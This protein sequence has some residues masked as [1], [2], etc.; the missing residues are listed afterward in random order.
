MHAP[1]PGTAGQLPPHAHPSPMRRARVHACA[2]IRLGIMIG[3][4]WISNSCT[5][6]LG[7][8]MSGSA[9]RPQR[10]RFPQPKHKACRKLFEVF[11][12][13]AGISSCRCSSETVQ[14]DSLGSKMLSCLF[15][16]YYI[17]VHTYMNYIYIHITIYKHIWGLYNTLTSHCSF[18]CPSGMHSGKPF[19]AHCLCYLLFFWGFQK[20]KT[21]KWVPGYPFVA[22]RWKRLENVSGMP[23]GN[24]SG[25][26]RE[27]SGTQCFRMLTN[28]IL[29]EAEVLP[30][31]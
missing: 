30:N 19:G 17:Y 11:L 28:T 15:N 24:Y 1:G 4:D 6:I 8:D 3:S 9:M 2:N 26:L 10:I 25:A 12:A 14:N 5:I 18:N 23:S 21:E 22:K 13:Y 7:L 29:V 31:N 20:H 16:L 27:N